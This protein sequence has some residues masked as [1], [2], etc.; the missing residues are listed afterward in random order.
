MPRS[1]NIDM[2]VS[3]P[4]PLVFSQ[5]A[6]SGRSSDW[7]CGSMILRDVD[8]ICNG[9][10]VGSLVY[11]DPSFVLKWGLS[12]VSSSTSSKLASRYGMRG[13]LRTRQSVLN[14]PVGVY[15]FTPRSCDLVWGIYRKRVH[16]CLTSN[17]RLVMMTRT[18]HFTS[19]AQLASLHGTVGSVKLWR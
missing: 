19:C 3:W 15:A 9:R 1:W 2:V 13:L 17:I 10:C 8:S 4:F 11:P 12:V 5:L 6:Q 16:Y 7:W 14:K 18:I